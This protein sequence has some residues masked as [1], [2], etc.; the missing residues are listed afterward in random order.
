MAAVQDGDGKRWVTFKVF[1]RCAESLVERPVP[2]SLTITADSGSDLHRD[3]EAFDKYGTPFTAPAGRVDAE[4]DLPGGLGG[5]VT[6]GSVRLEPAARTRPAGHDVRLQ[7][8]D[9]ADQII[10]ETTVHMEPPT[11]GPSRRGVRGHGTEQHGVFAF[12]VLTDLEA[13][14]VSWALRPADLTGHHDIRIVP[15]GAAQA[16][17]RY[18]PAKP[19]SG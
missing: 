16:V 13:Q 8:V 1:A 17:I 11:T 2:L 9:Q 5:T 10:A 7:V 14:T 6:G 19:A 3:I 15:A 18:S 12:E 4:I